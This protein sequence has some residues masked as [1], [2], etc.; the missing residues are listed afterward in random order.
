[1]QLTCV[2]VC[3]FHFPDGKTKDDSLFK[4]I[5]AKKL[6][7]YLEPFLPDLTTKVFRTHNATQKIEDIVSL[8]QSSLFM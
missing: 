5:N 2:C 3:V 6:S 7:A 4:K 1:M 8:K